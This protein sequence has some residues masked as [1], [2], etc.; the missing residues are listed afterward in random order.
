MEKMATKVKRL[1]AFVLSLVMVLSLAA[2]QKS[3]AQDETKAPEVQQTEATKAP[4]ETKAPV[5]EEPELE[6][7]EIT[8]GFWDVDE[9]VLAG[10][11]ML[12]TIS[13]KFNVTLVP[14]T[15]TWADVDQKT[16]LWASTNSLPDIW[17]GAWRDSSNFKDYVEDGV[18]RAIPSDLSK[19]PNLDRYFTNE[20]AAAE[21]MYDGEYYCIF[22]KTYG[23]VEETVKDS[24]VIYR[25]DLAQKAGIT[26]EPKNW[27]EFQAMLSAIIA[28]D[29]EGKDIGGLT[30]Q[31]SSTLG[32]TLFAY[33][34]PSA[35]VSAW[36]KDG[37]T[38][39]PG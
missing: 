30:T 22:R 12:D 10:D 37:Y 5:D 20:P 13:E 34:V 8:V 7:M 26:Q 38:Y 36:V 4:S 6:H 16:Q 32:Y 35:S 9:I 27:E 24:V 28:A 2:C 17:A 1:L 23:S 11:A 31:S 21:C 39:V 29:P 14:Q 33:S 15:F 18:I 25:W 3:P 19:Y